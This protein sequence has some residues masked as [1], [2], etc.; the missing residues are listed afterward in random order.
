MIPFSYEFS[1]HIFQL[2]HSPTTF[3][4]KELAKHLI[5]RLYGVQDCQFCILLRRGFYCG[6]AT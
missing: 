6:F 2:D 1:E 3:I 5:N 4:E